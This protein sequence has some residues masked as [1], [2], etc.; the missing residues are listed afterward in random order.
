MWVFCCG[1]VRSGSTVQYQLTAE[2]VESVGVGRALGCA[3]REQFSQLQTQYMG[4]KGF[5]VVNCHKYFE[6]AAEL[7]SEG[8]AKAVYIY[9]DIRDVIVS[10][11]N[12][13]KTS[14]W[15]IIRGSFIESTLT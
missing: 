3:E 13:N 9:R 10:I 15:Q 4:E 7:I 8:E 2:I 1:M 12:K 14:F 11:M 5:L 6:E